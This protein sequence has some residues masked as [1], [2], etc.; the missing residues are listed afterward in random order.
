[1]TISTVPLSLWLATKYVIALVGLTA[2]K[3]KSMMMKPKPLKEACKSS[4]VITTID[5]VLILIA[6]IG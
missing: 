1:M 3:S 4:L 2:P 5:L 6:L